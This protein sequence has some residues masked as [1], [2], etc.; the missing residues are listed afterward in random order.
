MPADLKKKSDKVIFSLN[1]LKQQ[2]RSLRQIMPARRNL[3]DKTNWNTQSYF[4]HQ[5]KIWDEL[6]SV[7]NPNLKVWIVVLL[8]NI[9]S[10]LDSSSLASQS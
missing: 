3:E 9:F 5:T 8:L 7:T 2:L 10:A 4:K 1:Q 6:A